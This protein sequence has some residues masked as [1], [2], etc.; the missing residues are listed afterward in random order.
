MLE[1]IS[2]LCYSQTSLLFEDSFA[3]RVSRGFIRVEHNIFAT[4]FYSRNEA[5]AAVTVSSYP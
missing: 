3:I 5:P 2:N 1:S 4:V